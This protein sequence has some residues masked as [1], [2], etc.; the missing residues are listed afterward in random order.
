MSSRAGCVAASSV[1]SLVSCGVALLAFANL[2]IRLSSPLSCTGD[3]EYYQ[4]EFAEVR[5]EYWLEFSFGLFASF[6]VGV[7]LFLFVLVVG[8]CVRR[9]RQA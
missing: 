6:V 4:V 5:S 1:G 2:S 8:A 9:V 7:T 3:A